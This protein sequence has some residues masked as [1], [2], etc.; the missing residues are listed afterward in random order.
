MGELVSWCAN[1]GDGGSGGDHAGEK[2]NSHRSEVAR[3]E[4]F[5]AKAIRECMRSLGG[6]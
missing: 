4:G 5:E 1:G 3:Y 2:W 6:W